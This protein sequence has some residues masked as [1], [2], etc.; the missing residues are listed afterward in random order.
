MIGDDAFIG[1][2]ALLIAPVEV[3]AGA[4]VGAGTTLTRD[5]PA[6]ALTVG[7]ARAETRPGWRRPEKP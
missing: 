1:S 4:T 3:G 7:R 6:G 2:G 5:A